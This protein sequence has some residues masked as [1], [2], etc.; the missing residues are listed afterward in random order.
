[1]EGAGGGVGLREMSLGLRLS[2][3]LAL[4]S[5]PVA[6]FPARPSLPDS[7]SAPGSHPASSASGWCC[8]AVP[9]ALMGSS[10]SL[11][12]CEDRAGLWSAPSLS[13]PSL[14]L[15]WRGSCR[16]LRTGGSG[17]GWSPAKPML[18]PRSPSPEGILQ[19]PLA[20]GAPLTLL[21]G[22]PTCTGSLPGAAFPGATLP[23]LAHERPSL[24]GTNLSAGIL[25]SSKPSSCL[26][27]L[28]IL[29]TSAAG[30]H[31]THPLPVIPMLLSDLG[32]M[33]G[34]L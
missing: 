16:T 4:V 18:F 11:P 34:R 1:M 6:S 24:K 25:G 28:L 31:A 33:K 29:P 7:P 9:A 30:P 20:L 8:N 17:G 2:L 3:F 12:L 26:Y 27:L 21:L 22:S 19:M 5:I 14:S 10:L 23:I 32:V 13:P 15:H